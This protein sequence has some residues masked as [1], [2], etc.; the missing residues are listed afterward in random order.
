MAT[1]TS[2]IFTK[3]TFFEIAGRVGQMV[4]LDRNIEIYIEGHQVSVSDFMANVVGHQ[5]GTKHIGTFVYC[6]N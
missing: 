3:I 1:D 4:S 5:K 6:K 2:N